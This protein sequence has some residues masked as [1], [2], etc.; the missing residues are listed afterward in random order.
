MLSIAIGRRCM[1]DSHCIIK[2]Y[3][4]GQAVCACKEEFPLVSEDKWSCQGIYLQKNVVF[5]I[6]VLHQT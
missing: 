1:Y 4:K 6:S 3:C 2:A 5:E